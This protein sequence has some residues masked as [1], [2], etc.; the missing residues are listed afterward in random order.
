MSASPT[1]SFA[2]TADDVAT[3]FAAEIRGKNVLVTGT[4]LNG[5]GYE[6]ALA[7]AKHASLVTITGYNADRLKLTAEAIKKAVPA[8]N[9]RRMILDLSSLAAIRQA[10]DDFNADPR[11][12]HVLIHNAAAAIGPFKLTVDGLENQ[13]GT[14]HV[15]P[16][17]LTKLLAPK[18]IAATTPSYTPRVIFVASA[19]HAF[20]TG[21]DFASLEHQDVTKYN[22]SLAYFQAKSANILTAIE[23]SK[24]SKGAIN[25]YSLH[26]GVIFTNM[27]Q[28]EES[29]TELQ[30]L[31][32]LGPDGQPNR[33]KFEWKTIAQGAAT[34][35]VAAFDPR[36]NDKPGAYLNDGAV[37]TESVA[38][39]SSD[40][41]VAEKLWAVTEKIIGEDFEF[42]S[43]VALL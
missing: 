24:R 12:I 31:G 41:V 39:H 17:L 11:P 20:G 5:I 36:L 21:I 43:G 32:M 10:T 23:L 27:T 1:F 42:N 22:P 14:D 6:T 7:I 29:V 8:A 33:E 4:S 16:F 26:P 35:V 18:L 9:I 25:A 37:A 38:P 13:F 15:G 3:A 40:P 30:A 34:T 19:A 2:S 28:K